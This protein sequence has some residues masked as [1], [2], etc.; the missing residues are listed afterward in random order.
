MNSSEDHPDLGHLP[1]D[2]SMPSSKLVV[3][4]KM[5]SSRRSRTDKCP[6]RMKVV[7]DMAV[8][9]SNKPCFT[10]SI[11]DNAPDPIQCDILVRW[12]K[13]PHNGVNQGNYCFFC[14][15]TFNGRF[16]IKYGTMTKF[17]GVYSADDAVRKSF[18]FLRTFAI[19]DMK[20]RY[21]SHGDSN[22]V[23]VNWVLAD[24]KLQEL[25]HHKESITFVEH[26]KDKGMYYTDYKEKFGSPSKNGKAA[27]NGG[28]VI[29]AHA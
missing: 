16:A 11:L 10:C 26:P 24:S 5:D 3:A 28:R 13:P 14:M 27:A 12:G 17:F 9:P 6:E 25:Q 7:R 21:E 20:K 23:M 19:E 22:S 1:P 29:C 8:I 2:A 4:K 18:K 15:K